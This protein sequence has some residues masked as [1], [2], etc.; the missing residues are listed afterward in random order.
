[1]E[2]VI[3]KYTDK[4]QNRR[5]KML[6][7]YNPNAGTGVLKPN[8]SDILDIFVKG[9]YEVTVYPTQKYH[10]ALAK[11]IAYTEPYDLVACS[12]GDGTLDEVV[13]GMCRRK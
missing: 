3:E 9:G 11:T 8:L 2:N 6:F 5:K 12:G 7:I 4:D 1:M 10:D 13:T